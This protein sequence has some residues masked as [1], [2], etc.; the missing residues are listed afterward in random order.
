MHHQMRALV[1]VSDSFDA[2]GLHC[3]E[4]LFNDN[5]NLFLYSS[6]MNNNRCTI[7]CSKDY[8]EKDFSF[9]E[10]D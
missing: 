9:V 2:S 4:F 3:I 1:H 8:D 10:K 5:F 6:L 7:L